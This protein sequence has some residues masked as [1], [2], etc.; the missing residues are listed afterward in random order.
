VRLLCVRI[1]TGVSC[2]L[3]GAWCLAPHTANDFV[4]AAETPETA[5]PAVAKRNTGKLRA[6]SVTP[7]PPI[8]DP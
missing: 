4:A 7:K 1:V 8:L 3:F 5:K 2:L 6:T